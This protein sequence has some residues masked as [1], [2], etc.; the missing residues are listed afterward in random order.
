MNG[1]ALLGL[2]FIIYS[3]FILFVSIKKPTSIWEMKKIQGFK[4]MFGENGTVVFFI[5]WGLIIGSLGVWMLVT[6][7]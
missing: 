2:V 6:K 3:V 1:W 5:I 4:K 7:V